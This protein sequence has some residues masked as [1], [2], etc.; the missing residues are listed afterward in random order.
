MVIKQIGNR[1]IDTDYYSKK[2]GHV[3]MDITSVERE[4]NH[5]TTRYLMKLNRKRREKGD[6]V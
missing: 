1:I 2:F 4:V 6:T 3:V 5:E